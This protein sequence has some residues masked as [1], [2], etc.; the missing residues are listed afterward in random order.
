MSQFVEC[1]REP[2]RK[3]FSTHGLITDLITKK[4]SYIFSEKTSKYI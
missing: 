3:L 1:V 4:Y 2:Q